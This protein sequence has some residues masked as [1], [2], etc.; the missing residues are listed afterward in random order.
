MLSLHEAWPTWARCGAYAELAGWS[1]VLD[2]EEAQTAP[3][4]MVGTPPEA[5]RPGKIVHVVLVTKTERET[6]SIVHLTAKRAGA[7]ACRLSPPEYAGS[8]GARSG[9]I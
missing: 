6:S 5:T 9:T 8:S 2:V 3:I 7:E 1:T 4:T